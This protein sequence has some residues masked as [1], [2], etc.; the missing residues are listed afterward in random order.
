VIRFIVCNDVAA[1]PYPGCQHRFV[2]ENLRVKAT[3]DRGRLASWAE[4]ET[5]VRALL[6]RLRKTPV[7]EG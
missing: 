1:V 2:Y 5:N 3:Y 6:D 7:T 4:I